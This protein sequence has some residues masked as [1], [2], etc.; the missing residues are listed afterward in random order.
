MLVNL[1]IYSNKKDKGEITMT[2]KTEM[3][4][5]HNIQDALLN[6]ARKNNSPLTIYLVTGVPIKCTIEG[7]DNFTVLVKTLDKGQQQLIFKHAIST[8]VPLNQI[9]L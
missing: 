8:I 3:K 9:N 2:A 1:L 6:E 5:H 7:F 4:T